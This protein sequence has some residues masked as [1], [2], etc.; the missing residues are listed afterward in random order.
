MM[1]DQPG[2]PRPKQTTYSL[3]QL[4]AAVTLACIVLALARSSPLTVLCFVPI[5]ACLYTSIGTGRGWNKVPYRSAM[6]VSLVVYGGAWLDESTGFVL[7]YLQAGW[8]FWFTTRGA[9]SRAARIAAVIA[10]S[11]IG[12]T[13]MV[14][15]ALAMQANR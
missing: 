15:Y 2:T 13:V 6:I 7:L 10:T 8:M 4:V 5:V 3:K 1:S 14:M 12:A 9:Q 11:V